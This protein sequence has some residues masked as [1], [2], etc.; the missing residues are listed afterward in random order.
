MKTSKSIFCISLLG[1][2]LAIAGCATLPNDGANVQA[3][4]YE[5]LH[6]LRYIELF[7]IV[8][9]NGITGNLQANV[10]NSTFRDG[11]TGKDSAPQAWVESI[12]LEDLKKQYHSLGASMNGPRQWM[13][14]LD[15]HPSRSQRDSLRRYHAVVC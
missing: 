2:L 15:R 9:G 14:G 8:G 3:K 13:L 11:Y 6:T 7:I 12:N 10:Y 4:H 5:N 1:A